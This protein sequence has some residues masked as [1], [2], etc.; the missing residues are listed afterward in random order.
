MITAY[1]HGAD[2]VGSLL[3]LAGSAVGGLVT[4]RARHRQIELERGRRTYPCARGSAGDARWG[5]W[6]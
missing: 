4:M 3:L 2:L 6:R 5:R 1:A